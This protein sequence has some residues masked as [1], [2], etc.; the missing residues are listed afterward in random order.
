LLNPLYIAVSWVLLEWHRLFATFMEPKSGLSWALSILM[1]VVTIRILLFRFFIK[2]VHNQRKMQEM[3]PKIQALR[4]KHKNDRQTLSQEMM[5]L[6]R[7]EGFNPLGGCLPILLQAPIFLSLF[8]VLRLIGTDRAHFLA[9]EYHWRPDEVSSAGAAKLFGAPIAAA[10]KTPLDTLAKLGGSQTSTR[11]VTFVLIVLMCAATFIT[12]KQIMS[13]SGQVLEGQQAMIQKLLLYGMP[14]SLFVSGF[15]FPLGVLLYWFTNNLWTM[16]QQFYILHRMPPPGAKKDGDRPAIDPKALA[17][18]PGQKPVNPRARRPASPASPEA[19]APA[20]PAGR[21][22]PGSDGSAPTGAAGTAGTA[23]AAKPANRRGRGTSPAGPAAPPAGRSGQAGSPAEPVPPAPGATSGAAAAGSGSAGK[24]AGPRSRRRGAPAAPGSTGSA[25]S[26]GAGAS[27]D[28]GSASADGMRGWREPAGDD[29]DDDGAADG[30]APAGPA[31]DGS[32]PPAG[33][34]G[35]SSP[36]SGP[37]NAP[38]PARR[39]PARRSS[40]TTRPKKKR[41]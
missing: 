41:R 23:G 12:Q 28:P 13:R 3:Q 18:R 19:P 27:A 30:S 11:V 17:P 33:G 1:L 6:Q 5:K 35:D 8:H 36:A 15:L 16:G 25:A 24:P 39:P 10:F 20:S 21:S 26:D 9:D 32:A 38:R 7:E 34:S 31:A 40:T 4:E 37:S 29:S 2:Q 14:I 22:T